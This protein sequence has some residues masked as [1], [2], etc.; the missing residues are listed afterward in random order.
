MASQEPKYYNEKTKE[1]IYQ[2]RKENR[3]RYNEIAR[4]SYRKRME[5]PK[6]RA[7]WNE[8][9]RANS[10]KWRDKKRKEK[11]E[12]KLKLQATNAPPVK[13]EENIVVK[14]PV[15]AIVSFD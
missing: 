4:E 6:A 2:Y 5:D 7:H 14:E 1:S 3:E 12:A 10:K 15:S 11:Q 13:E 8:V 9:C